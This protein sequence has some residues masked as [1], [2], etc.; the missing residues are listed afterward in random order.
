[1]Q[2]SVETTQGLERRLTITV[3]AENVETE[4]KKN[5]YNNCQKRS[6][7]TVSVLVKYQYQ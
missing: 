7:S 2:V 5:A 4:V 1:M 3:P 6:V